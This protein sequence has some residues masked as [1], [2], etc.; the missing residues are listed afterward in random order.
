MTNILRVKRNIKY[1]SIILRKYVN[2]DPQTN[3]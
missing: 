2:I 3:E 1:F